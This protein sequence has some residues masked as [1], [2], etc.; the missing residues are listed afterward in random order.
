MSTLELLWAV[1]AGMVGLGVGWWS[2]RDL[3]IRLTAFQRGSLLALRALVVAGLLW[4]LVDPVLRLTR[5][6]SEKPLLLLLAD[7]SKSLFWDT[8]L[9]PPLYQERLNTLIKALEDA[10]Y[11]IEARRFDIAIHPWDSFLGKGEGTA[12]YQAL[13]E[14]REAFPGAEGAILVSDG[15]DNSSERIAGTLGLPLWTVGAGPQTPTADAAIKEAILPPW[16]EAGRG[17]EVEIRFTR[18]G[19]SG[20]LIVQTPSGSRSWP[21]PPN[22]S[23]FRVPLSFA[24]AGEVPVTFR[25]EVP[26]DPNPA[27]NTYTTVI[28][29]RPATP[30][31]A[32]WA[33]EITPDIAFLRRSLERIGPVTLL[34]AKKPAGFTTTPDTL[35]WRE[36]AIHVLY[37]F[38]LRG[39]DTAYVRRILESEGVPWVV[40]GPSVSEALVRPYLLRLGWQSLG[41]LRGY[42]LSREAMLLLRTEHLNP[43]AEKIVGP[44]GPWA[45]RYVQG[46]QAAVGFLGEGWW[47]LRFVPAWV[48]SWD[49]LV[50]E[51][52]VWS[53]LFY[54]A[55]G[56]LLPQ[57]ARYQ[58]GETVVWTGQPPLSARL[59]IKRPSGRV[60]T[61]VPAPGLS[62]HPRE[63]GLHTYQLRQ[64]Q[65]T[66]QEG[67]FWVEAISPEM[68]R[69]GIDTLTLRLLATQNRGAFLPWDSLRILPSLIQNTIP[70]QTLVHLHTEILPFHEW[71]P[72]LLM[73]LGLLS[74][75]WLLRRYW[76]LY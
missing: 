65:K 12:L 71:W 8:A 59:L 72:W 5:P 27:N 40:W 21:L 7:D 6:I 53:L 26:G 44:V 29:V 24:E 43:S 20:I 15:L 49:S 55:S 76:G 31:I 39:E 10:G 60:D 17:H 38:P 1:I 52:A 54:R 28:S 9:T 61:L 32:I 73:L 56:Q 69:L 11:A 75:E 66:L 42:S 57:R 50:S 2:Y 35:S 30:R 23:V 51:L 13:T 33:G 64:D 34:L 74:F 45:Y 3:P 62:Y 22:T 48:N 70:P 67:A 16:W 41:P 46:N 25:L 14:M 19:P 36:Y 37:N 58:A 18:A 47:Q 68:Q 4:L 63:S